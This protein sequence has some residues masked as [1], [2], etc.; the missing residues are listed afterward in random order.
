MRNFKQLV[1]DSIRRQTTHEGGARFPSP[2]PLW[3]GGEPTR[4]AVE[5]GLVSPASHVTKPGQ[6]GAVVLDAERRVH[7]A[8]KRLHAE[9]EVIFLSRFGYTWV[10]PSDHPEI[11]NPRAG[12]E[13][14]ARPTAAPYYWDEL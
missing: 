11:T 8:V 14:L 10:V 2:V 9:G 3:Y 7:A 4:H 5:L 13:R 1:L 12:D 6:A